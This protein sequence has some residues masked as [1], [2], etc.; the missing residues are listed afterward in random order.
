MARGL[1]R[2]IAAQLIANIGDDSNYE[3]RRTALVAIKEVCGIGYTVSFDQLVV[4]SILH[5]N[6]QAAK[7]HRAECS[8]Y[9][10]ELVAAIMPRLQDLS[11][12]VRWQS[13]CAVSW[14]VC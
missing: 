9:L 7:A 11:M 13:S 14:Y 5:C 12:R 6:A 1:L 8:P 2:E 10:G 4:L 3:V